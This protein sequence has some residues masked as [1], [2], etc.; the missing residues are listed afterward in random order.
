M[1]ISISTNIHI[2]EGTLVEVRMSE[3]HEDGNPAVVSLDGPY[4]RV[5][6]FIGHEDVLDEIV[7]G[8]TRVRPALKADRLKREAAS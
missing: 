7:E 8:L 1:S 2:D 5:S 3:V 4:P 6:L